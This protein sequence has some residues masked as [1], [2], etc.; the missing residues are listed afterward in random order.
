MKK[1]AVLAL[2]LDALVVE[3]AWVGLS[4]SLNTVRMQRPAAG[5]GDGSD[6]LLIPMTFAPMRP[7]VR[8]GSC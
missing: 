4:L 5:A 6:G 7:D 3:A 8:C 2:R 1:V